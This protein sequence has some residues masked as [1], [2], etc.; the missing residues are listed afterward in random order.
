MSR[1]GL[2]L[3][4]TVVAGL[5]ALG[6]LSQSGVVRTASDGSRA[7]V[8]SPAS[9]PIVDAVA[10]PLVDSARQFAH[11]VGDAAWLSELFGLLLALA[12][13]S[14]LLDVAGRS[15]DRV[16]LAFRSR[17]PPLS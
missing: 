11:H 10:A 15:A 14:V 12:L 1:R 3:F 6:G 5:C 7:I 8:V 16:R 13:G 2:S 17:A 4:L 9:A